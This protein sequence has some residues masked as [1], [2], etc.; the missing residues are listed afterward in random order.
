M[1]VFVVLLLIMEIFCS[2]VASDGDVSSLKAEIE[3]LRKDL[4]TQY[5]ILTSK[6]TELSQRVA[7]STTTCRLT[8]GDRKCG[9]C[10]CIDDDI[11]RDKTYCDCTNLTPKRDCLAFRQSGITVNGVYVITQNNLKMIKVYCDQTTDGGGWTVFQRRM[12]GSVNFNVDWL[13]YKH[14]FGSVRREFWLGNDNL[15]TMTL[16]GLYSGGSEL[17]IDFTDWNLDTFYAKYSQFQVGN[18]HTKYLLHTGGYSGNAGHLGMPSRAKFT[19][20]DN[21]NDENPRNCANIYPGGW[22]YMN[23]HNGQPNGVYYRVEKSVP[24]WRGVCWRGIN[25]DWL[26]YSLKGTEMKMR[27]KM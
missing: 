19:T 20:Y 15:F 4:T 18:E 27:R 1:A 9:V 21:D 24:N 17:R 14:G 22:W 23:C 5:H 6:I 26:N 8:D 7:V 13:A 25:K 10:K 16:Q 12:D 3:S 11:L 2:F